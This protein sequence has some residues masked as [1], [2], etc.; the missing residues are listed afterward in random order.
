MSR[1]DMKNT[2][3]TEMICLVSCTGW[4]PSR[5]YREQQRMSLSRSSAVCLSGSFFFASGVDRIR[6][7]RRGEMDQSHLLPHPD[8]Q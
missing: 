4:V 3:L 1:L 8:E 2:H 6:D 5:W 7:A